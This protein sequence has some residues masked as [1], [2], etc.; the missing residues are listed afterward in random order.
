VHHRRYLQMRVNGKSKHSQLVRVRI[1]IVDRKG[2]SRTVTRK[3]RT[4]R[5]LKLYGL[6]LTGMKKVKVTVLG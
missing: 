5:T 4:N 3:V 2:R 1:R 6:P